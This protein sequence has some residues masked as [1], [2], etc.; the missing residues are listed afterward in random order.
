MAVSDA[1]INIATQGAD[2]AAAKLAAISAAGKSLEDRFDAINANLAN[3]NNTLDDN[4][5]RTNKLQ[6]NFSRIQKIGKKVEGAFL[7]IGKALFSFFKTFAKFS[8]IALAGE[9]AVFATALAS[10][11]LLLATGGAIARGYQIALRGVATAAAG[12]VIG[13]SS[14]AAAVRQFQ[15][16]QLVPFLG[17]GAQGYRSAQTASRLS[18]VNAGL[19][20][21]EGASNVV[22]SLVRGGVAPANINRVT[23]TLLNLSGGDTESTVGLAGALASGDLEKSLLAV[24]GAAG[25]EKGSLEGVTTMQGLMQ[26]LAGGGVVSDA[27][28]GT[29]NML[30]NTLI[31][32]FKTAFADIKEL[33]ADIG[34]PFLE[35]LRQSLGRMVNVFKEAMLSISTV[36]QSTGVESFIPTLERFISAIVEFFRSNIVENVA[37]LNDTADSFVNFFKATKEFFLD[38]RDVLRELSPASSVVID[39]FRAIG[40]AAGGR[41]LFRGFAELVESNADAFTRFGTSIGNVIG[42]VFD[43]LKGGNN[44]FFNKLDNLSKIFNVIADT[45]LPVMG[46]A[47]QV[48]DPF[49]RALPGLLTKVADLV[50]SALPLVDEVVDF[51]L[52]AANQLLD[53]A[54]ILAPPIMKLADILLTVFKPVSGLLIAGFYTFYKGAQLYMFANRIGNNQGFQNMLTRARSSRA[55]QFLSNNANKILGGALGL[56]GIGDALVA[57]TGG[58]LVGGLSTG[59]GVGMMT[60]N[61]YAGGVAGGATALVGGSIDAYKQGRVT[62]GNFLSTV[63][64]GA[65]G[66]AAL[67]AGTGGFGYGMA[68]IAAASGIGAVIGGLALLGFSL[69]GM[70]NKDVGA[71]K[72]NDAL[73]DYMG[74]LESEVD[75]TV[76]GFADRLNFKNDIQAALEAGADTDT[77]ENFVNKY[78]DVLGKA[79]DDVDALDQERLEALIREGN[80]EDRII[81]EVQTRAEIYQTNMEMVSAATGLVGEDIRRFAEDIGFN[82]YSAVGNASTAFAALQATM[83]NIDL[84]RGVIADVTALPFFAEEARASVRGDLDTLLSGDIT[85]QSLQSYLTSSAFYESAYAGATP[86]TAALGGIESLM[87]LPNRMGMSEEQM[88]NAQRLQGVARQALDQQFMEMSAA[89]NGVISE[90]RLRSAFES[91][92]YFDAEYGITRVAGTGSQAVQRMLENQDL[93]ESAYDLSAQTAPEDMMNRINILANAGEDRE[94]MMAAVASEG[95]EGLNR[96]LLEAGEGTNKNVYWA[97]QNNIALKA[98]EEKVSMMTIITV[99]GVQIDMEETSSVT[100]A[101]GTEVT[102]AE[103]EARA[104]QGRTNPTAVQP[105]N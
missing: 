89:T 21:G 40:D 38:I 86:M 101:N 50:D 56:Y 39:M 77:F 1:I 33:F 11:N 81:K 103:V 62:G 97:E 105:I 65:V 93:F 79:I 22:S 76:E 3:F 99:D 43:L 83:N 98:I 2:R 90:D 15:Q 24:R 75:I 66:L 70:R 17:G 45:V 36:L 4:D 23:S 104:D 16:A 58:G 100:T 55:G 54:N 14:A 41:G 52:M 69:W 30:A 8:F 28:A 7:K 84:T 53:V 12:V 71:N 85:S 78:K 29:G 96:Y 27:F 25:F 19:L 9:I 92:E 80:L 34:G 61:P 42:A 72:F 48:L 49:F 31:G 32:S 82:L 74:D 46:K 5:K 13:L 26:A 18:S 102:V 37:D 94:K 68:G 57:Q 73:N 51:F 20:G 95:R 67:G 91:R 59:L 60:R 10:V 88:L 6:R 35:P 64:G 44:A 63:G 47:L 87:T